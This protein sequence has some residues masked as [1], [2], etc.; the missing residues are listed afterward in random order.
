MKSV[1]SYFEHNITIAQLDLIDAIKTTLACWENGEAVTDIYDI[2]RD[3][4]DDFYEPDVDETNYN[5][6]LGCDFYDCGCEDCGW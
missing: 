1:F 6:Y 4:N 2:E 5:P 3:E